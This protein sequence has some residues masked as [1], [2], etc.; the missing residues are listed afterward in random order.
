MLKELIIVLG[1][2]IPTVVFLLYLKILLGGVKPEY[3][4]ENLTI[5]LID[6]EVGFSTMIDR[7]FK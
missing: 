4:E 6:H 1:S 3:S 2:P 5:G 7:S